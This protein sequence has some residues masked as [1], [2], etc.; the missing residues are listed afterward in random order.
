[1]LLQG[2]ARVIT[3]DEFTP[4]SLPRPVTFV[5]SLRAKRGNSE[6]PVVLG[7][8]EEAVLRTSLCPA[9]TRGKCK[10]GPSV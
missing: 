5:L 3:C 4:E 2:D 10:L 8:L 7:L 6:I 1:M 9:R